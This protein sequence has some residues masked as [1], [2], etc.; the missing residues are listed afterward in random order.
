MKVS[1]A[2]GVVKHERRLQRKG[3]IGPLFSSPLLVYTDQLVVATK[4]KTSNI[5]RHSRL[6]R[7]VIMYYYCKFY[8]V[9][10][11]YLG[12]FE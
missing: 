10:F 3:R 4:L 8:Y 6:V 9:M 11:I 7:L 12:V 5:I 1:N 2:G